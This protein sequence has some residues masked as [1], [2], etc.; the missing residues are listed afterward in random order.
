MTPL[1]VILAIGLAGAVID[2]HFAHR[3]RDKWRKI[4]E[5]SLQ[6]AEKAMKLAEKALKKAPQSVI[7]DLKQSEW[8]HITT[9]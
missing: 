6:N 9:H 8:K 1:T 5:T 2:C 7:V 3:Q 4:A